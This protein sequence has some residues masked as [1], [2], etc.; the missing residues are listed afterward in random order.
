MYCNNKGHSKDAA[1]AQRA[2]A[3]DSLIEDQSERQANRDYE[4]VKNER[5]LKTSFDNSKCLLSP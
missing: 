5:N 2:S 3:A 4:N 1:S